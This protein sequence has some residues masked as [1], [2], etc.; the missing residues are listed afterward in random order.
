MAA[1]KRYHR[2]VGY[3]ENSDCDQ[4][5]R[6]VFLLNNPGEFY[7]PSCRM[8][9]FVEAE[10]GSFSGNVELF[11]EVRV[12]FNF[13]PATRVYGST[14]IVR[15]ESLGEVN[16][17]GQPHGVY[18]IRTP[19]VKTDIRALKVA[20]SILSTLSVYGGLSEDKELP[21]AH[22]VLLSFDKSR[23]DFSK[24][25]ERLGDQWEE[26]SRAIGYEAFLPRGE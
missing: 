7:C 1:Y 8:E 26:A 20:E 12:E 19:L 11:N 16:E 23:E 10:E 15:D 2:A 22:E 5:Y 21:R 4:R 3:C 13:N 9:G 6:G 24:D 14:A 25:L 17:K 18:V